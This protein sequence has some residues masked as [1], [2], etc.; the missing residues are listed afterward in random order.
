M[1]LGHRWAGGAGQ[2]QNQGN[3]LGDRPCVRQSATF[4]RNESGNEMKAIMGHSGTAMMWDLKN[5]QGVYR[6]K[7]AWVQNEEG[8]GG[9]V[10]HE[11]R[12]AS[13]A[14]VN[15]SQQQHQQNQNHQGFQAQQMQQQQHVQQTPPPPP[16]PQHHH[17]PQIR[18]GQPLQISQKELIGVGHRRGA[19]LANRQTFSALS[20][21]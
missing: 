2:T 18:Q 5:Q 20:H 4:R 21:Q 17:T 19:G 16:P 13:S 10:V 12:Q 3:I 7:T 11:K 8:T 14:A 9:V 15:A 6:G 1:S